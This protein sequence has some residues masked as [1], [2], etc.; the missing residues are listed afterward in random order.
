MKNTTVIV[1]LSILVAI[2]LVTTTTFAVLYFTK[3]SNNDARVSSSDAEQECDA[4]MRTIVS[5]ALIYTADT[6]YFPTSWNDLIPEYLNAKLYCPL[7]GTEYIIEWN[8]DAPPEISCPNH[9]A[10]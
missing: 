5:A 9:G 3:D 6:M 7:D 8:N 4:Q 10:L 2:L 1:L